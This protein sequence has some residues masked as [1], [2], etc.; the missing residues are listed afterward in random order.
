VEPAAL[1][2]SLALAAVTGA[3]ER[4]ALTEALERTEL[5]EALELVPAEPFFA[6]A[7]AGAGSA[8]EVVVGSGSAREVINQ[9]RGLVV[10]KE[11]VFA[12]SCAA[13][14]RARVGAGWASEAVVGSGWAFEAVNQ[15]AGS[16]VQKSLSA[17][18]PRAKAT[19]KPAAVA[20]TLVLTFMAHLP[21]PDPVAVIIFNGNRNRLL[22]QSIESR[23]RNAHT[24]SA[25]WHAPVSAK[26]NLTAIK[27]AGERLRHLQCSE[28]ILL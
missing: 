14:A 20:N 24:L 2:E 25:T 22:M 17:Q 15:A 26:F 28:L 21:L 19:V 9:V 13:L 4:A 18:P 3:L 7:W 8:C 16:V 27:M 1:S 5:S 6:R 10:Q 23:G 12:V 11:A